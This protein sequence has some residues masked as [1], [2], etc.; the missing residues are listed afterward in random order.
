MIDHLLRFPDEADAIAALPRFRTGEGKDAG[1]DTSRCIPDTKVYRVTGTVEDKDGNVS[2]TRD[3]VPGWFIQIGLTSE[4]QTL[5][6][7]AA[8]TIINRES[9]ARTKVD[10]AV[11]AKAGWRVEP[12]FAGS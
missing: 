10:S 6:K 12:V 1:W 2:E 8:A 11:A 5:N 7:L 9:K 4:D 3:Y